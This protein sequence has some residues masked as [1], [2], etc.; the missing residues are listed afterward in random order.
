MV[1]VDIIE[2]RGTILR[3]NTEPN[4]IQ[5]N[6]Q[7]MMM[8]ITNTTHLTTYACLHLTTYVCSGSGSCGCC[9]FYVWSAPQQSNSIQFNS[10]FNPIQYNLFVS[11]TAH[12]VA[13]TT[14]LVP[15]SCLLYACYAATLHVAALPWLWLRQSRVRIVVVFAANPPRGCVCVVLLLLFF[16]ALLCLLY[17][18]WL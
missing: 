4:T 1:M 13:T 8:T 16:H 5:H 10:I 12:G 3:K 18:R 6:T 9:C 14:V 17:R 11:R 15:V 7:M 2:R